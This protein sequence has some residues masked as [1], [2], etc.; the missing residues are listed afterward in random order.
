MK[1]TEESASKVNEVR[2]SSFVHPAAAHGFANSE[3][4]SSRS[5]WTL[6]AGVH[7]WSLPDCFDSMFAP[8]MVTKVWERIASSVALKLAWLLEFWK[9]MLASSFASNSC[10]RSNVELNLQLIFYFDGSAGNANRFNSKVSLRQR[11][12]PQIS[13]ILPS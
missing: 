5:G 8:P 9:Q 4:C 13:P 3:S 7:H 6:A 2:V 10:V 12:R 11:A 1:R